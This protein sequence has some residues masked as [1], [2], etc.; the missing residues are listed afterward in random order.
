MMFRSSCDEDAGRS[1]H[2]GIFIFVRQADA[3]LHLNKCFLSGQNV[4]Q[5]IL[6]YQIGICNYFTL[7]SAHMFG[8][9]NNIIRDKL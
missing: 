5:L 6:L 4:L 8:I 3:R 7:H 2:H 9:I 1:E